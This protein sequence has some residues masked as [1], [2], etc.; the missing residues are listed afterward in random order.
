MDEKC[1][2]EVIEFL[3][4]CCCDVLI[5]YV[6]VVFDDYLKILVDSKI[7]VVVINWKV[8]VFDENC[9][10][11]DNERGGYMV[12]KVV[13]DVGYKK[14]VYISGLLFKKDVSDCLVGYKR[15]F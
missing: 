15:V 14:I 12:M 4:S 2:Y 13:I 1:E 8:D 11:V 5:F 9:F 6:E 3:K 7:F 10:V